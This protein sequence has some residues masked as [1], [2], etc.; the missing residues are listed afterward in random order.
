MPALDDRLGTVLSATRACGIE[1]PAMETIKIFEDAILVLQH[2]RGLGFAVVFRVGLD[3]A[4]FG[5][6]AGSSASSPR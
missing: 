1:P 6:S 4:D 2:Q 3:R 5:E